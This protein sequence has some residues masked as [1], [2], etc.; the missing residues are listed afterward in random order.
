MALPFTVLDEVPLPVALNLLVMP[1]LPVTS[2]LDPLALPAE[3][4]GVIDATRVP[5][6]VCVPD[7]VRF[8]RG[9]LVNRD[10]VYERLDIRDCV[11]VL[12]PEFVPVRVSVGVTVLVRLPV[13]VSVLVLLPVLDGLPVLV[14]DPVIL[15]VADVLSV[16]VTLAVAVMDVVDV[17]DGVS[18]T[19]VTT[20]LWFDTVIRLQSLSSPADASVT[21]AASSSESTSS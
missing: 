5:V 7:L 10:G 8:A 1:L 9:T 11:F 18:T 19:T 17:V 21:T 4:V 6:R 12:V 16:A 3:I 13:G 14:T 15:T 2:L 20:S